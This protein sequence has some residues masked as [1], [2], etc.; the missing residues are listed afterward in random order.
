MIWALFI[1]AAAI[2]GAV[3]WSRRRVTT[4]P[5]DKVPKGPPK[6]QRKP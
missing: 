4:V 3:I 1:F 2:W 6:V 5:P